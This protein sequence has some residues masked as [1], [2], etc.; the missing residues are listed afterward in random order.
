MDTSTVLPTDS[1]RRALDLTPSHSRAGRQVRVTMAL[2][3]RHGRGDAN[4]EIYR[5]I[6]P[7]VLPAAASQRSWRCPLA[8]FGAAPLACIAA[9]VTVANPVCPIETALYDPGN[10]G[11]HCPQRLQVSVS[12][13]T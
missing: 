12:P 8:G 6:K 7:P 13:G 1:L 9:P 4:E 5:S 3:L 11:H 2:L 10:G